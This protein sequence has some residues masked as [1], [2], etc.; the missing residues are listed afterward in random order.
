MQKHND[1]VHAILAAEGIEGV[2][3]RYDKSAKRLLADMQLL[4]H[5]LS[6][7]VRELEGMDPKTVARDCL[8]GD[9]IVDAEPVER[10]PRVYARVGKL[11]TEDATVG[12]G[13][14]NFD[15]RTLLRLPD[16]GEGVL[17]EVD[18]ES[19]NDEVRLTCP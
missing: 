5:V 8:F 1:T 7:T 15:I 6:G 11:P 9:P 4:S 19:Q 3:Q 17:V 12:E 10:E 16:T 14:T 18:V 13:V 2:A